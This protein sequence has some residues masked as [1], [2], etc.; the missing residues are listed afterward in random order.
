VSINFRKK[1]RHGEKGIIRQAPRGCPYTNTILYNVNMEDQL[2][3][4]EIRLAVEGDS[5]P[6]FT[7]VLQSGIVVKTQKGEMLG[8][9]LNRFPGFSAEYISKTVQTIFLNGIAIDDMTTPL[10]GKN[11]TLALSAAMPGLA[12]AI[13]RKN[14]FHAALRTTPLPQDTDDKAPAAETTT[15]TV[16]LF[17]VVARERGKDLLEQ[18]VCINSQSVATFFDKRPH[19]A[20]TIRSV[21]LNDRASDRSALAAVLADHSTINLTIVPSYD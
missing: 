20:H 16:K 9:F 12:G 10:P 11:P 5:L 8:Q 19:L 15:V 21:F 17:N 2:S 14:S 18:G 6:L 13:F 3:L 1:R 7:T 4:P